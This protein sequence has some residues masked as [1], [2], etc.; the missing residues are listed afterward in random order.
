M[1]KRGHSDSEKEKRMFEINME[2]L[3]ESIKRPNI[4]HSF[5][6]KVK[7]QTYVIEKML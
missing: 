5:R 4:I 2:D 1:G 3:R 6:G 7:I